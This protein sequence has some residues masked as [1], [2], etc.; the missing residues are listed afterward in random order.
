MD[1]S[2]QEKPKYDNL[3]ESSK[4]LENREDP[5]NWKITLNLTAAKTKAENQ[6]NSKNEVKEIEEQK[7]PSNEEDDKEYEANGEDMNKK[8]SRFV[9]LEK[10]SSFANLENS[11]FSHHQITSIEN[12]NK[13]EGATKTMTCFKRT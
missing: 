9:E 12:Q 5:E 1:K 11:E 2:L 7:P 8:K 13:E 4:N 10:K 3:E 6:G